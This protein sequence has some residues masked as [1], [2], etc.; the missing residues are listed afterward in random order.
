MLNIYIEKLHRGGHVKD[1]NTDGPYNSIENNLTV[2]SR[3]PVYWT[4]LSQANFEVRPPV[5]LPYNY[6]VKTVN[7]S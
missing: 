4:Q 2:L 3:K 5:V 1:K 7:T 6:F